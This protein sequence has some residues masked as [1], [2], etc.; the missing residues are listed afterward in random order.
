MTPTFAQ[1]IRVIE[2][3]APMEMSLTDDPVGIQCGDP[4]LPVRR[5]LFA[6]DAS[7][8]SVEQALASQSDLLVTHHPLLFQ[9]L[10]QGMEKYPAGIAFTKAVRGNLAVYS[11]HTNLDASPSGI[12]S[13]F[14]ELLKL[15][16]TRVLC[17]AGPGGGFKVVVYIPV[18]NIVPVRE[19]A[20]EAGAGRIGNYS[21]CSFAVEGEGTFFGNDST[22][23]AVGVPGNLETVAEARL[24]FLVPD[25]KL[26]PVL[27]AVRAGHPYEEPAVDVYPLIGQL[28][29]AGMGLK[30]KLPT[31][32]SIG[33]VAAV[34]KKAT[35][36]GPVRL[37]GRKGR[38][39]HYVAVCAGSGSS[40]I[41]QVIASGAEL[42]VTGDVKYHDARIAEEKGL[43]ILDVGH[44]GPEKYGMV[45]F[46][47]LMEGKFKEKRWQVETECAKEKD[48]F[49]PV[50]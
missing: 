26:G 21:K 16:E 18:S 12:N 32:M 3:I 15:S 35:G 19:A 31:K 20:F 28:S 4:D 50:G 7:E 25:E 43:S 41:E 9:P 37:V 47:K 2:E 17:P 14:A 6:L 22:K 5:I 48:P 29:H 44:F 24:E 36:A 40:L 1:I 49:G 42:F 33:E 23:P 45:R 27:D 13:S 39:V 46:R 34:L 8:S 10:G 11:A 38:K 30:G